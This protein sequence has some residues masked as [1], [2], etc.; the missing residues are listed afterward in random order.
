LLKS[1]GLISKDKHQRDNLAHEVSA[2]ENMS[3]FGTEDLAGCLGSQ[4]LQPFVS[5][6]TQAGARFSSF[7]GENNTIRRLDV[8]VKATLVP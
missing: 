5:G 4:E 3:E 2:N 6:K 1:L 8:A 7:K